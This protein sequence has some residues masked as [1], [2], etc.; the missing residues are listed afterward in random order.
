MPLC[1]HT[2][3]KINISWWWVKVRSFCSLTHLISPQWLLFISIHGKFDITPTDC[4]CHVFIT[5]KLLLIDQ[6]RSMKWLLS[7]FDIHWG[8]VPVVSLNWVLLDSSRSEKV[9]GYVH[10]RNKPTPLDTLSLIDQR[11]FIQRNERLT[12]AGFS[13]YFYVLDDL[14]IMRLHWASLIW[15]QI[16]R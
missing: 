1:N 2:G 10:E 6:L 5:Y 4:C 3:W 16:W 7:H 13:F 12:E 8:D 14:L 9:V 15:E 11:N